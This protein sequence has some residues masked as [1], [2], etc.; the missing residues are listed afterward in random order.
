MSG[1]CNFLTYT[2]S[3]GNDGAACLTGYNAQCKSSYCNVQNRCSHQL[4][5]GAYCFD[6]ILAMGL[7]CVL[8][9]KCSLGVVPQT[10][11]IDAPKCHL[12][13]NG[14]VCYLNSGCD[15]NYCRSSSIVWIKNQFVLSC[16]ICSAY[17]LGAPCPIFKSTSVNGELENIPENTVCCGY[18]NKE[19]L[20]SNY[21]VCLK[22]KCSGILS[23]SF[24]VVNR[25]VDGNCVNSYKG[26][27][28]D[29]CNSNSDCLFQSCVSNICD[30]VP[31]SLQDGSDC[32]FN[33]QCE[34]QQCGDF[35]CCENY[36]L[37]EAMNMKIKSCMNPANWYPC[38]KCFTIPTS[39]AGMPCEANNLYFG[40]CNKADPEGN[41]CNGFYCMSVPMDS[42]GSVRE[43]YVG[44]LQS[45][46]E[47]LDKPCLF[48]E[49]CGSQPLNGSDNTVWSSCINSKCRF[50]TN[51][52]SPPNGK[53]IN[54]LA[55]F[56]F[57]GSSKHWL[58]P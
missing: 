3:T 47:L 52:N 49:A 24:G 41:F 55:G 10:Y 9:T 19:T 11:N 2:C 30:S 13:S 26:V 42:S 34:S 43:I 44:K 33:N 50:V 45:S 5:V 22:S 54:D 14:N 48:K 39:T 28:G 20:D 29:S 37:Y 6:Y 57:S 38:N 18:Y 16:G 12:S 1:F 15:S 58:F 4:D 35:Q 46:V 21:A 56:A 40:F 8:G 51:L 36:R 7:Q 31:T 17:P 25:V 27:P 53:F 23:G 32:R